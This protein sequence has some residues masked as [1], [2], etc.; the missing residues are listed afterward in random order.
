VKRYMSKFTDGEKR[1]K[2]HEKDY[3]KKLP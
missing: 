3:L 2:E 1:E